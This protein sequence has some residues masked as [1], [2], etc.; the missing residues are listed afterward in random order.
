MIDIIKKGMLAGLGAGII[1]KEAI[2]SSLSEL[3]EKGKLSADEAKDTA[4]KIAKQSKEQF[5]STRNE[6]NTFFN[7]MLKKANVATQAELKKLEQRVTALENP[8]TD[9]DLS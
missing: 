4:E 9:S 5:E 6:L 3:V 1:T 2:E 7:E 8:S